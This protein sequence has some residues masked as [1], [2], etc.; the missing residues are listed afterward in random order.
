MVLNPDVDTKTL[1]HQK[2][3]KK[4]QKNTKTEM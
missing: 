1:N 2:N 3:N 4:K